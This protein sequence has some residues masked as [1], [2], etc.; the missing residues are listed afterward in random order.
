MAKKKKKKVSKNIKNYESNQDVPATIGYFNEFRAEINSKFASVELRFRAQDKRF[1]SLDEKI[2]SVK[3]ELNSKFSGFE[4]KFDLMFSEIKKLAAEVHRN[5]AIVEE[6]NAKNNA[7]FD[8]MKLVLDE[9]VRLNKDVMEI[10]KRLLIT[11]V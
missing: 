9:N 2:D 3:S 10:K 6:Q 8:Q 4:S 11:D 5:G 1:D 7:Q